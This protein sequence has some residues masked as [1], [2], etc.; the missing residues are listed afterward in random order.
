MARQMK[1]IVFNGF[2][3]RIKDV[4]KNSPTQNSGIGVY[5]EGG[6]VYYGVLREIIQLDYYE[7]RKV[8][9]LKCDWVDMRNKRGLKEDVLGFTLVNFKNLWKTNEPYVLASQAFQVFYTPD[10]VESNWNVVTKIKPRD[11]YDMDEVTLEGDT[12]TY[13]DSEPHTNESLETAIV[14]LDNLY[15]ESVPEGD[16]MEDSE[17]EDST[18]DSESEDSSEDSETEEEYMEDSETEEDQT[19]YDF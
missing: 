7:G 14:D 9:L 12:R 8:V 2:K 11:V 17:T 16:T 13:F 4:E 15:V 19:Y 5:G 1:K 10:P 6:V 3:F 18:E